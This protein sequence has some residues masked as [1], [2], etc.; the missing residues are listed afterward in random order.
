MSQGSQPK[1]SSLLKR[2]E[3]SDP[4]PKISSFFK[5]KESSNSIE[6]DE[7]QHIN[8]S[9]AQIQPLLLII[10]KLLKCQI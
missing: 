9:F 6:T 2:K 1:I 5:L 8:K 4:Q 10:K 3:P 7:N